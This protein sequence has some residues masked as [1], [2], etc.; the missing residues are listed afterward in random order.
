MS[1]LLSID[2]VC[3][4]FGSFQ[5]LDNIHLNIEQGEF[6]VLLGPSGCGKTTLLRSIAGFMQPDSGTIAIDGQ[7]VSRLPPYRR[8]LNTVFQNYALFPHMT[9][10]ENVAYGPRRQGVN[11]SESRLKAREALAMVGLEALE[12]RYPRGMSGGQQQRVALA[13]AIVNQP[14]L[15]L[16]DEPLSALDMKLR[17]RMQLELKHLQA[18]LGIAFIFVTHDQEEA[19]TIADRIVVMNAGRIEQVGNSSEIYSKPASRF[20][21]D[22]IGEANLI[23]YQAS[24]SGEIRLAIRQEPISRTEKNLLPRGV[25]VL[26]PEHVLVLDASTPATAGCHEIHGTVTD[27]VSVGSHTLVHSLID[28]QPI[29]ARTMGLP[30]ADLIAGKSVRLGFNPEHLHLIGEPV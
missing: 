9:V 3:K 21:A 6:I 8:P 18:K 25:A 12:D 28:G 20:V 14:K 7:D 22:F 30:R 26:R 27:V 29:V 13:R 16:L 4:H 2:S 17:K 10:L 24:D 23:G 11:R 15:L 1:V 5:A 19:M